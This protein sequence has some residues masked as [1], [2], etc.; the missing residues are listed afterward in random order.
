MQLN[1]ITLAMIIAS[2]SVSAH[3]ETLAPQN[4]NKEVNKTVLSAVTVSASPIHDHE[5]FDVPSQID[6]LT[7]SEKMTRDSGSLGAMLESI[8]G[9]NNQSA[10]TQ[11]GKPVV[12]GMTGNRVKILSNGQSTDYQAYGTR[13]LPNVDPYL[14]ERVE[15]IRGPQSVLYGAEAMGGIVNV[16]QSE[17]PYGKAVSGEIATE[18]NTNNQETM[19]GA[20]VG[21]GSKEFAIQAG[22]STR[23]ADNFTVPNASSAPGNIAGDDRPL[24]VGEVPFTNFE[25]QAGNIGIGY[26]QDWGKIELRHTQWVSKQNYL[27]V[28]VVDGQLEALAAGQKLQNDETQLKAEFELGND[29]VLK[30]SWTHTRN[31][32]EAS[33][34]L[35]YENMAEDEGTP[36]YLDLL[37]K[38]DDVKLAI[39]HPQFGDFQGELG[40]ELTEKDQVL[41][42]GELTPSAKESKRAIYLF[43]EADYDKWLVQVGARYDWHEVS[44]PLDGI[45]AQFVDQEIFDETNNN[46]SFDVFSGSLGSTY[47]ID[48]NWSVAANLA[49][50][51]RAPTIFE[52]YAGGE[53]GGVQAYQIGNPDLKAETS[54]NTDLS[55]RWQTAK[56]QMVATVYQNWIDNY[57]YLANEL[58]ADGITPQTTLNEAGT[59]E[60]PVMKAQQTDAVM[61]GFEFSVNH[62]FNQAW[63]TDLALELIEGRDTGES[64]ELP[65][66][67]A[68]NAKINVHY[69]PQDFAG[70]QNQ[71]ITVGVK[72]VN[73]KD[74]AGLYEPFSQFDDKPFGT[75]S[76]EA[77]ALWNL[78]YQT[79]VKLDKQNLY[80]AASVDNVFDTAYVDF[81]NTYKG[82]TLNTGRN[83]QLK[84]R[85]DF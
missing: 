39:E 22:V 37:V 33:H 1:K 85:L 45:N 20:K 77:Y 60:I 4:I 57:I 71:K 68:N 73:S 16:I 23:S 8:P 10:G 78:G 47:R 69:Q 75:A 41:R 28:E 2:G 74:A 24:F 83:I 67:P 5:V 81:L 7:G 72:L 50:G 79:Q 44:A 26:Q 19:F 40:F 53:H 61:T 25:N 30:P 21:A 49:S 17:M 48:S 76:T 52:L 82:Y 55:L 51:F 15:V 34:D 18:Y 62:Q 64:R 36:H 43:E 12:R 32:R 59:L 66:M 38:R 70:L 46:R 63:S 56:T 11:S 35:P 6:V 13:H 84:A 9:V 42:S 54:L 3:A 29:W 14:A 65:L 58:E 80:L 31:A 27:G